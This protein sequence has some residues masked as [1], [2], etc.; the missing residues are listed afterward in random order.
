LLLL[1][2]LFIENRYESGK[3]P[4]CR[5]HRHS[6]HIHHA[7]TARRR[8]AVVSPF[9]LSNCGLHGISFSNLKP[10]VLGYLSVTDYFTLFC[11]RYSTSWLT[12]ALL[13]ENQQETTRCRDIAVTDIDE[14]ATSTVRGG[15]ASRSAK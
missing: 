1:S 2:T 5:Q 12:P 3:H 14:G 7:A 13:A 11:Y 6:Q 4:I 9:G 15:Q 8:L 10:H